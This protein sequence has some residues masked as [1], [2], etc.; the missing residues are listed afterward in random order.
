MV[1]SV[2][3]F[4][5]KVTLPGVDVNDSVPCSTVRV[6]DARLVSASATERSRVP[7]KSMAV[8]TAVVNVVEPVELIAVPLSWLIGGSL[9]PVTLIVSEVTE[10]APLVSTIS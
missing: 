10:V 9:V 7:V 5:L 6:M 3:L 2:P 1:I 8:L 4:A